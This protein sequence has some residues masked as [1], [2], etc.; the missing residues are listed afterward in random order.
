[1]V[2]LKHQHR[3]LHQLPSSL[4][5]LQLVNNSSTV[6]PAFRTSTAQ[7]SLYGLIKA[8]PGAWPLYTKDR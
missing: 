3:N 5:L 2:H 1:M 6:I 4:I 7:E 8:Q